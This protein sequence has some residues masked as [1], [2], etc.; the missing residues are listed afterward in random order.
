MPRTIAS[1]GVTHKAAWEG[2]AR[3]FTFLSRLIVAETALLLVIHTGINKHC[4]CLSK[5]NL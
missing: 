1:D 4:I 3:I 5:R 2:S